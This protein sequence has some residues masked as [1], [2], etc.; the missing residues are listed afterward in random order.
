MFTSSSLILPLH[1]SLA[2]AYDLFHQVDAV[3]LARAAAVGHA[4]Q[5]QSSGDKRDDDFTLHLYA[6]SLSQQ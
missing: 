3:Q 1:A 5:A 2:F 4:Q 6:L